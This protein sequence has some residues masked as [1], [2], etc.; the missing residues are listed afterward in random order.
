MRIRKAA[1]HSM[2]EG[3]VNHIFPYLGE[4]HQLNGLSWGCE[5]QEDKI[6]Q[7]RPRSVMKRSSDSPSVLLCT[8]VLCIMIS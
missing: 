3:Q 6:R 7:S 4:R 1:K 5:V 8:V 2:R